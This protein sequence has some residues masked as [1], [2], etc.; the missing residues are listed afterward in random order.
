[1]ERG[2]ASETE[3]DIK[4]EGQRE[5]RELEERERGEREAIGSDREREIRER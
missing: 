4:G 1:M 5:E 3:R 2:R